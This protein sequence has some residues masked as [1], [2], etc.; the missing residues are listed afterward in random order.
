M[1]LLSLLL[2]RHGCVGGV[3]Q[4]GLSDFQYLKV[5]ERVATKV[6]QQQEQILRAKGTDEFSHAALTDFFLPEHEQL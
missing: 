1:L 4:P 5:I 3:L 6:G 2:M